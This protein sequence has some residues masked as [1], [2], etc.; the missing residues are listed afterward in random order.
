MS[1]NGGIIGFVIIEMIFIINWG[2]WL[3]GII[4]S[5]GASAAANGAT[6]IELFFWS[7]LNLWIFLLLLIVNLVVFSVGSD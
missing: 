6:G 3:G 5:I 4:A 1:S 2:I 7:Y